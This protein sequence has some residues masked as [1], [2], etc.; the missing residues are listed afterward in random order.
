LLFVVLVVAMVCKLNQ[1]VAAASTLHLAA[2]TL[3][4]SKIT[5]RWGWI[6]I[7]TM[8]DINDCKNKNQST[9]QSFCGTWDP[10]VNALL[11]Y[12]F[13]YFSMIT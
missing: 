7:G 5:W 9:C 12:C 11:D 2:S 13:F 3:D 8:Q 10:S 4:Q 1:P 6:A